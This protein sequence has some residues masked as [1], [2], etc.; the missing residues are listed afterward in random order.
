M[1]RNKLAPI[2]HLC[3]HLP[4]QDGQDDEG[5]A[6]TAEEVEWSTYIDESVQ[7][8]PRGG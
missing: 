5:P 3:H 2:P 6:G 1:V 8:S 7:I 4:E